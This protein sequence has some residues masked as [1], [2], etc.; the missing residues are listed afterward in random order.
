MPRTIWQDE[1]RKFTS[2]LAE[3]ENIAQSAAVLGIELEILGARGAGSAAMWAARRG[4]SPGCS[5]VW[6]QSIEPLRPGGTRLL[7]SMAARS[8]WNNSGAR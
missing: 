8:A 1:A 7:S 3:R 2:W 4:D 6:L 5:R